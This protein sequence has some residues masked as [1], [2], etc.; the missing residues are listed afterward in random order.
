MCNLLFCFEDTQSTVP[1]NDGLRKAVQAILNLKY[2]MII[3][4]Y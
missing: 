3:R 2:G 4:M 1:P